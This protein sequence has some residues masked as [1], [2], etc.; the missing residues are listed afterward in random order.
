MQDPSKFDP[1]RL[2]LANFR[3]PAEKLRRFTLNIRAW[4]PKDEAG[5]GAPFDDALDNEADRR[6]ERPLI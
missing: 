2:P 3:G 4:A 6:Y 5:D 1:Q